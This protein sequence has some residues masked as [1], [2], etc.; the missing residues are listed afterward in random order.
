[1]MVKRTSSSS[2]RI[3]ATLPMKESEA[4]NS[5]I[6]AVNQ[7]VYTQYL[8]VKVW[9]FRRPVLN[10]ILLR[11]QETV[12]AGL[13]DAE[14]DGPSS[15]LSLLNAVTSLSLGSFTLQPPQCLNKVHH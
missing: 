15:F 9:I 4:M 13:V 3:Q 7:M 12:G 11:L 2:R 1:M 14:V 6:L 5:V 8:L 10:R